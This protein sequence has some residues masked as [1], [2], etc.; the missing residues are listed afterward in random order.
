MGEHEFEGLGIEQ[1]RQTRGKLR[2]LAQGNFDPSLIGDPGVREEIALGRPQGSI[3][4]EYGPGRAG[5]RTAEWRGG[6]GTT[7]ISDA[8]RAY[9]GLAGGA[10]QE[11]QYDVAPPPP[12]SAARN[13][14]GGVGSGFVAAPESVN[15]GR[16]SGLST[17]DRYGRTPEEQDIYEAGKKKKGKGPFGLF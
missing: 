6:A 5:G 10:R 9:S 2:S 16:V 1:A 15:Y 17:M 7:D 14:W 8:E 13:R 4:M 11:Y 3:G 12:A